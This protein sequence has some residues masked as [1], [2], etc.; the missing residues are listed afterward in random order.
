M[1]TTCYYELL[2]IS[3]DAND[4]A[5]KSAFRKAAMKHHPDKNPGDAGAEAI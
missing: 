1:T 3:R 2:E 5:I 4:A